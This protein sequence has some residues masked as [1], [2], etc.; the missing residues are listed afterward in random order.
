MTKK[1]VRCAIYTR[2][3]S[4]EGLDQ[5]FNS[6]EAQREACE[7][8][9]LSQKHEGWSVLG[10]R[11]DDGGFSGG[12][13]ERPG[14]KQLL[15]DIQTNK[16]DTIVVYKVDRLTRSLAD[17]AKII[18]VFDS[19]TVSF[20]SVTQQF[21]TTS[22]MG[23]LTLNVLLSF[24]QFER[25]ITGERIRDKIAASRRKGM[26][27]GG[28]I[29]L[30]YDV[31]DRRLIVNGAESQIVR[32]LFHLY[33]RLGSVEKVQQFLKDR[34]ILSK[35]RVSAT[36]RVSGGVSYSRG[37]LYH[38]LNNRVYIGEVV[39]KKQVFAGQHQ[40]ILRRKL[41][42]QVASR[43]QENNQAKRVG[44]SLSKS[45]LL[46]GVLFDCNGVRF[47][48]THSL[49][50]GKRYRYYTSQTVV[51]KEGIRP[52]I[53]RFPAAELEQFVLTQVQ[54]LLRTP[55]RFT[56][57]SADGPAKAEA[58]ERAM[59]LSRKWTALGTTQQQEFARKVLEKVTLSQRTAWIEINKRKLHAA[60]LGDVI[61]ALPSNNSRAEIVKL[62]CAF[63]VFHQKGEI[64]VVG[65]AGM[66]PRPRE[67]SPSLVNAIAR[68]YDWRERI[69]SGEFNTIGQLAQTVGLTRRY[70]R[71]ILQCASLSPRIV[72][73]VIDG[74][75]L[76]Q[77]RLKRIIKD[78]PR[79]WSQQEG[80]LL[81]LSH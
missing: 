78:V 67:A 69:L 20:V 37:A 10:N 26:W 72:E 19:H 11:Y 36:K 21:N 59:D 31:I 16:L 63:K 68:A 5:S 33:L 77:L 6:L 54:L 62:T 34:K 53:P 46:M 29:P 44:K 50:Q 3:S 2:K 42:N 71:R 75:Q 81:S 64:Q 47:T 1:Y 43:L 35:L 56:C 18:E 23:R 76:A 52:A 32:K 48:P 58:A 55:A 66:A 70:V 65:P 22:S 30:G 60:L 80:K 12:S 14:L 28:T 51:R 24:A 7:A 79:D 57:A 38:L 39:H 8:Y 45:S 74:R 61:P 4:E 73:A 49:K 40:A 15:S 41:W 9:V 25:E 27:M 17:F 13:M